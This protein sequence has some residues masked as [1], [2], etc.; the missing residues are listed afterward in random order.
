MGE[1]IGSARSALDR[2]LYDLLD[3]QDE[4]FLY[5][6][7]NDPNLLAGM[8][9]RP[10]ETVARAQPGA[11]RTAA[12]RCTTP[13]PKP[14]RSCSR[15]SSGR[16]R[17]SSFRTATTR[18]ARR[19]SR[20]VQQQI[21]ESEALVY[22][23]GIDCSSERPDRAAGRGSC[24]AAA[25]RRFRSRFRSPPGGRGGWPPSAA[26]EPARRADVAS[27]HDPRERRRA[28]RSDRRQR[29]PHRDHSGTA[30]PRSRRR[31]TSPTS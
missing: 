31:R 18:P 2:F 11:R 7:S 9:H 10:A 23:V 22:A 4:I 5:Q 13:C 3:A 19:D 26:A 14:S 16:R 28:A 20:D 21:R 15:A 24:R 29:R 12:P 8:D 1:K 25:G 30:R 6:F 17:C 27:A